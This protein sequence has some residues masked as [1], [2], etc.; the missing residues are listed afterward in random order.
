MEFKR[1]IVLILTVLIIG[2]TASAQ[3]DKVE[4]ARV[5]F[6]TQ[7]VNITPSEAQSFWPIY[8]EYNDKVKAL[9]KNF[10]HQYKGQEDF[11][12]E[13]EADD[14]LNAELKLKQSECDLQKEYIEKFKKVLGAKKTALLR[15]A[16]EEFKRKI[17]ETIKG[18]GN[19]S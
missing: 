13:K 11:K 16:E 1:Y 3:S 6:I 17:I 12:T 14:F 19:D 4:A 7:K 2:S 15:R 8:N 9:R 10:R 5:S 18:N